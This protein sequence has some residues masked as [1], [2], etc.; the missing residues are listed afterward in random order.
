MLKCTFPLSDDAAGRCCW[1]WTGWALNQVI[2][3][4]RH[5]GSKIINKEFTFIWPK[6]ELQWTALIQLTFFLQIGRWINHFPT[7]DQ[8]STFHGRGSSWGSICSNS[9]PTHD[10]AK[11]PAEIRQRSDQWSAG[12]DL[13]RIER[14]CR[15][16]VH[17]LEVNE[18][19][20]YV[21]VV[22]KQFSL[23]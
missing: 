15:K 21:G 16:T 19:E 7:V 2:I 11:Q 22:N 1:G 3:E 17:W 12:G 9:F 6:R 23:V 13:E 5:W 18:T 14:N 10:G 8:W 4:T 20:Y